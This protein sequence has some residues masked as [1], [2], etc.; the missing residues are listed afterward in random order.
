MKNGIL[1]TSIKVGSIL[2]AIEALYLIFIMFLIPDKNNPSQSSETFMGVYFLIFLVTFIGL[3]IWGN[4]NLELTLDK[5]SFW[6][7]ILMGIGSSFVFTLIANIY[8]QIIYGLATNGLFPVHASH[9]KNFDFGLFVIVFFFFS[10]LS[11]TIFS[12][13]YIYLWVKRMYKRK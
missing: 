3:L 12:V 5:T 7:S 1:K 11:V 4:K 13:R 6:K 9:L 2:S 8:N 10:F